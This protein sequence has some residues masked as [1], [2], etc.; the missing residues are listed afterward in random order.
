[1]TTY[2]SVTGYGGWGCAVRYPSGVKMVWIEA[3]SPR[4]VDATSEPDAFLLDRARAAQADGAP[5]LITSN[6][7]ILERRAARSRLERA[8]VFTPGNR[9]DGGF[10]PPDETPEP[11]PS[12]EEADDTPKVF[13]C[14]CGNE[15]PSLPSLRRHQDPE[16]GSCPD[17]RP[18]D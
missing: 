6:P 3:G 1:M 18:A 5:I 17:T 13:I 9:N 15:Y 4:E 11:Q 12:A 10:Y 16:L 14:T 8:G 7:P 2:I